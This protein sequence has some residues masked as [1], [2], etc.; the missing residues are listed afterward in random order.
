MNQQDASA[1][2][3]WRLCASHYNFKTYGYRAYDVAAPRLW[4]VLPISDIRQP[5]ETINSFKSKLK[6]Y[7]FRQPYFKHIILAYILLLFMKDIIGIFFLRFYIFNCKALTTAMYLGYRSFIYY[8]YYYYYYYLFL[9]KVIVS[10]R[11]HTIFT[12]CCCTRQV[13]NNPLCLKEIIKHY[14]TGLKIGNVLIDSQDL[15]VV[16]RLDRKGNHCIRIYKEGYGNVHQGHEVCIK[17]AST[18]VV[19][20]F[21]I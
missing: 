8:Y 4:N 7:L 21:L 12:S 2:F 13:Q 9:P 19:P 10:H 11:K 5:I 3:P 16:E 1:P 17:C 20:I 15:S 6:T 18:L 14:C